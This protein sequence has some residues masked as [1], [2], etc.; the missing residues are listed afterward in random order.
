MIIIALK[1]KNGSGKSTTAALI[2]KALDKRGLS[3]KVLSFAEPLKK[4]TNKIVYSGKVEESDWDDR[5][6]KER[7]RKALE[8]VA[9]GIKSSF[10][11][12]PFAKEIRY[13]LLR[14]AVNVCII[15]DL[16]FYSEHFELE[17]FVWGTDDRLIVIEIT[18]PLTQ[19]NPSEYDLD[20]IESNYSIQFNNQVEQQI[21]EILDKIL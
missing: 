18:N 8:K 5:G 3:N 6:F 2:S 14:P 12:N 21:E 15:S 19:N 20:K 4:L 9:E 11:F 1:G 13:K 17:G 16:R 7:N 10:S